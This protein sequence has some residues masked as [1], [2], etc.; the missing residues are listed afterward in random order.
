MMVVVGPASCPVGNPGSK[1]LAFGIR[2]FVRHSVLKILLD[3]QITWSRINFRYEFRPDTVDPSAITR[4]STPSN[5]M[6]VTL[7]SNSLFS[8]ITLIKIVLVI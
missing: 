7:Q 8:P 2:R 6:V 3:Y 4:R 1:C 5:L